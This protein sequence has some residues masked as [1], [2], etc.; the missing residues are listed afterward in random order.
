M[1]RLSTAGSAGGRV[2]LTWHDPLCTAG[3]V[4]EGLTALAFLS[5]LAALAFYGKKCYS[6]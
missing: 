3:F 2:T 4:W 1:F 6:N 5:L